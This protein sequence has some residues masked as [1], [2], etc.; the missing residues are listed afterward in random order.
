MV[1]DKTDVPHA[2]ARI[3]AALRKVVDQPEPPTA[4]G[5]RA[6]S[7]TAWPARPSRS[8]TCVADLAERE[9]ACDLLTRDQA[10]VLDMLVYLPPGGDPRRCGFGQDVAGRGEGPAARRRGQAGRAHVLLPRPRRVPQA[11][12][13][14]AAGAAAPGLR[15][16]VPQPRHR[17]GRRGRVRTTTARTGRSS[18]RRRWCRSPQALPEAERFD[19][20]VIDEAQDFAESWWSAVLAALR[21]PERR[22]PLRLR[23]RGPARLRPPGPADRRPGARSRSTRTCA[24]PSR[25]PAPS[26]ASRRRR[27]GSA[28]GSG[29]PVRFVPVR[30]RGRRRAPRT[31][32]RSHCWTSGWPN[33]AVALLTTGSRHP[34]QAERQQ[35]GPGRLLVVVLGRRGPLLRARPRLQGA[36]AAG[37]RARRQRLP[38]RGARPG[39]AL[40]RPVPRPRPA[41]RLRRPG[42]D[43]PR[44]RR[45]RRPAAHGLSEGVRRDQRRV[46]PE[47]RSPLGR[48]RCRRDCT[49]AAGRCDGHLDRRALRFARVL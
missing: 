34:V 22:L 25:S 29:V 26:P 32:R 47:R 3:E 5:R 21:D 13:R 11:A 15:R 7:S 14:H 41:R 27:C 19:A 1:L 20:I 45:G 35:A 17:L 31:T 4:A 37:R 40:R 36:G 33:E 24:T 18:S 44:R 9:A 30:H 2:A 16:H 6:T 46:H 23:R 43:P 28:V 10:D 48:R 49:A 39:D 38:R 12:G 42:A 8:R